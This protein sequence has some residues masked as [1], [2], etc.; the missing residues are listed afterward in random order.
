MSPG[1]VINWHAGITVLLLFIDP[2]LAVAWQLLVVFCLII[3]RLSK[4]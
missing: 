2:L 1:A 4:P 3:Y